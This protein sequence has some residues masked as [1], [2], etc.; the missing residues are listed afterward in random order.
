MKLEL[1]EL[2]SFLLILEWM[3]ATQ[4][5]SLNLCFQTYE[6]LNKFINCTYCTVCKFDVLFIQVFTLFCPNI[7]LN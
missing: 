1:V 7:Y 6:G 5:A 2:F 4:N 3:S